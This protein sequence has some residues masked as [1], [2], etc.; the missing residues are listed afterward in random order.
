VAWSLM[1]FSLSICC[2]L[3]SLQAL[4]IWP[5]PREIETVTVNLDLEPEDRYTDILMNKILKYGWEYTYVPVIEFYNTLV[6]PEVQPLFANISMK[7]DEY[8]P[9]EY[10][11]ELRGLYQLVVQVGHEDEFTLDM[12]VTLNMMYEWM[13]FCTSIVSEDDAG[14]MWHGRNLDWNFD[15]FSLWNLTMLANYQRGGVTQFSTITWAGYIGILTGFKAN[16][17]SITVDQREHYEPEGIRGNLMAIENGSALVGF[18]LRDVFQNY[19]TFTDTLPHLI[20]D[21]LASSVYLIMGG[22]AKD[23]GVVV[24]RDRDSARDVWKWGNPDPGME[25]WY[26]VETN[27]DHWNGDNP[28][29]PRQTEAINALNKLGRENLDA[30]TLFDVMQTPG[31]LNDGTQ[32]T[33]IGNTRYDYFH[34]YGW[35]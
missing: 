17:F 16:G 11:R 9:E 34:A 26:L 27:Y 2:F 21:S 20:N 5:T 28:L 31:V 4:A 8:F 18:F 13:T 24:T 14:V 12:I 25:D 23:E 10:A 3:L 19:S 30:D 15:G 29:D 22:L 7:M 33:I 32:Y 1:K 35:Q 6:P